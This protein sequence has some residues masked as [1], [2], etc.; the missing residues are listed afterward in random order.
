[1][2]LWCGDDDNR[3]VVLLVGVECGRG[4]EAFL[5]H[6]VLLVGVGCGRGLETFL[7]HVL[8]LVGVG[9]GRGLEAFLGHVLLLVGVELEASLGF[10]E[11]TNTWGGEDGI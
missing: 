7:G 9:C 5:G 11:N 3:H 10:L 6:V 8:L 1:M 2:S 4:L